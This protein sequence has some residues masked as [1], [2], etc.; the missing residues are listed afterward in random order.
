LFQRITINSNVRRFFS[1]SRFSPSPR[2]SIHDA[3]THRQPPDNPPP[4][5]PRRSSLRLTTRSAQGDPPD[6]ADAAYAFEQ[7][8]VLTHELSNLLDGSMRC[9]GIAQQALQPATAKFAEDQ[10]GG[11]RKQLGTVFGALQRMAE[12]VQTAM[13]G[14]ATAMG[15]A[16]LARGRPTTLV[17]AIGHAV[18]VVGPQAAQ[19]RT[20][21]SLGLSQELE[22]LPA[23]PIYPVVL[24]A[25]RN[26]LESI[27]LVGGDGLIEV[28][29][30]VVRP[31]GGSGAHST[32]DHAI[33]IEV[34]DNGRG[35]ARGTDP[36]RVF[37]FGFS[38]KPGG[39][40]VGL[41]LAREII[42]ELGGSIDLL[43]RHD[44]VDKAR[45]GA[46]L[47]CVF[48]LPD[49]GPGPEHPTAG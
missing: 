20:T 23:G 22:D 31:E 8:T 32:D 26:A 19:Q 30:S 35:F 44:R 7:M 1:T 11:A 27:A 40:G 38:T 6:P 2:A 25:L 17:E 48:P 15:S 3:M 18:E 4:P 49:D 10:L 47:R 34:R 39:T 12:L 41:A 28:A 45:P 9:L 29:A 33:R 37:Q 13:L 16:R 24:N 43:E 5:P 42:Q 36:E 14:S 46:V 21:I